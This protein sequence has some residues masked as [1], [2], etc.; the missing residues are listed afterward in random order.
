MKCIAGRHGPPGG[1]REA[2]AL[3]EERP[4]TRHLRTGEPV[5][6]HRLASEANA[7]SRADR[8]TSTTAG[9][10]FALHHR[11]SRFGDLLSPEFSPDRTGVSCRV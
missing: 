8:S 10:A 9:T 11:V 1:D 3:T 2:P 4:R 6:V 7:T 5:T